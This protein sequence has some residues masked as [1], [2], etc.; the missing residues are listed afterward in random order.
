M[1]AFREP[2]GPMSQCSPWESPRGP[3]VLNVSELDIQREPS[4]T[5][6][7]LY[8]VNRGAERGF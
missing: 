6:E 2:M 7:L 4:L 1:F 5:E 8:E 3:K